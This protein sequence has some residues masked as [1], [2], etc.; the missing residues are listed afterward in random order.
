MS[1]QQQTPLNGGVAQVQTAVAV[2]RIDALSKQYVG[3]KGLQS[4]PTEWVPGGRPIYN[5]LPAV[6]ETYRINFF[7]T[8]AVPNT[9]TRVDFEEIG[10][11]YIPNGEGIF[12]PNSVEVVASNDLLD[13]VIKGGNIVWKYGSA[14]VLPT[15][16]NL[17]ELSF[18]SGTYLVSYQLVYDDS[19]YEA[20]YAVEDYALTGEPLIVTSSTDA[21][22]G[23][24]DPSVNA[25][26][27]IPTSFWKNY[28]SY[29]PAYI[30]PTQAFLAWESELPSAY[31][32][33]LM[34]CPPNTAITGDA[35]LYY[36]NDFSSQWELVT[37]A[38]V[39]KD[40]I[41]QFF[42]L[43]AF[44]PS[45]QTNWKVEWTDLEVSIQ[46]IEVSGT[47]TQIRRPAGARPSATLVAYP[48][49]QVPNSITGPDGSEIVPTYCN[50]AYV[51]VKEGFQ[52]EDIR[53]VRN[54][55]QRDFTPISDWLTKPWDDNLISLYEQVKGYPEYWIAPVSAMKQEYLSLPSYGIILSNSSTLGE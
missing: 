19:P 12:G 39:E 41:G 25:F 37:S 10:Y 6:G 16:I 45:F 20:L 55:T 47:I 49:N 46:S 2:P 26:L 21:F 44:D 48:E 38:S 1:Q 35:Y 51:S 42:R 13:I 14:R 7:D 11:V 3:I 32:E 52:I 17:Q 54:I 9:A 53:D 29:F 27:N 36:Y 8:V 24:R 4:R 5:R 28:D 23:W 31:T 18:T 30:Q 15:V 40:T 22:S 50:L 33:I 34:R 43:N